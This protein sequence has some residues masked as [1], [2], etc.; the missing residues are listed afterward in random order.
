MTFL[1]YPRP[2][3]SVGIRNYVLV[4]PGG[5]AGAKICDFVEGTKTLPV[6]PDTWSDHTSRDREMSARMLIGLGRNPNVA[7]VVMLGARTGA[8]YDE[9]HPVRLADAIAQSGKRVEFPDNRGG[10]TLEGIAQGI[11]LAREMVHEASKIRREPC[12]L[13]HLT[14]GVKCGASDTTSGLA[15]NPVIGSLYDL[16]VAAG[17]TAMLGENTELVGAEQVLS[18]RGA[19]P[20]VARRIVAVAEESEARAKATG[21]DIRTINPVPANIAGG[22]SSLEEKSLG[23]I[24]K[25]G[26]APVQGVLAYGERP[27]GK[28]LYFVDNNPGMGIFTGYA[29]AG[30]QLVMFQFGGGGVGAKGDREALLST[31]PGIV[32]PML[33]ATANPNTLAMAENSIDFFSGPVLAGDETAAEA[34]ERLLQLVLDIASGT[35]TKVETIRHTEP[36]QFYFKDPIF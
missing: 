34:A 25:S 17:G 18:T 11:K 21:E 30:A 14:L 29:A 31:S 6:A 27:P 26:T 23:A 22:I 12:D 8:H 2:N 19:T 5:L 3:G 15:G 13:S 7:A 9:L 1:G 35:L 36:T 20:E 10:G 28:G 4:I 16:I 24:A 33:W 32:A